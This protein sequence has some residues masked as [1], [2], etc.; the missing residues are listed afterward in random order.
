MRWRVM[1]ALAGMSLA[2]GCDGET[3]LAKALVVKPQLGGPP[4]VAG[5]SG[6]VN[7]LITTAE[8]QPAVGTQARFEVDQGGGS[9]APSAV[10]SDLQGKAQTIWTLGPAPVLQQIAIHAGGGTASMQVV[11]TL[12]EPWT[13]ESFG[14]VEA[15]LTA[16]KAPGS[17]EDLAFAP[18]GT[19]TMG[20]PGG[21]L[22]VDAAG[23]ATQKALKGDAI[24]SALGIAY[25]ADGSLWVA[26]NKGKA[27]RKVAPDGT[28]TTM[29]TT[30]GKQNL[31]LP[32]D[33]AVDAKGRVWLTDSCLGELMR[34]DPVAGKVDA[35]VQ[36]DAKQQGG[37]NGLAIAKDGTVWM[38]TEN[39]VLACA[40]YLDVG[41]FDIEDPV[42]SLFRI[43]LEGDKPKPALNVAPRHGL[44]GDGLT[45]DH[46]GNLYAIFD[47]FKGFT[48]A[49][50][51]VWLFMPDALAGK[52]PPVRFLSNGNRLYGNVVFPPEGPAAKAFGATSLY[53]SLLAVPPIATLRGLER[54][55]VG[56][57]GP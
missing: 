18:D 2:V 56:I 19:L 35:I 42:A 54:F 10:A 22:Q 8:G 7:V 26:D 23:H 53:L 39:V 52:S 40:A 25:D 3:P 20:V 24:V 15:F 47:R 27:L 21:L 17:T 34:F 37:P 9:V 44:Y 46:D 12:P 49:E 30:D 14:D 38:T 43:D 6:P 33:V 28:V 1:V 51:T 48:L 11:A 50:T 13:P 55:V 45:F 16:A 36:F 29:L 57:P 4:T 32:N 41:D 5:K 31:M